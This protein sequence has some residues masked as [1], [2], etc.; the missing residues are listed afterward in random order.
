MSLWL[1]LL[2]AEVRFVET[3]GFGRVRIA[4]AGRG[5]EPLLFL[6]GANGLPVWLP[7]FELLAKQFEVFVPEHPGFGTSD[8]PP[9]L[10]NIGD[11]AMYYLDFLDALPGKVPLISVGFGEAA[12]AVNN[13]AP[14]IDP[15]S[16]IFPGHSSGA[17][18][19]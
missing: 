5:K 3:P 1:D 7:V 12:L 11:L 13:A 8:N 10:R 15:D 19:E 6:H 16:H 4:E 17:S 9:W 18:A 2:G 14:I